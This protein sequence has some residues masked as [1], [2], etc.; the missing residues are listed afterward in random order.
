MK[1]ILRLL[2]DLVQDII[3]DI[4]FIR[5]VKGKKETNILLNTHYVSDMALNALIFYLILSY[6]FSLSNF[7][8]E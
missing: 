2:F 8:L 5:P 3:P 1:Q 7:L 4:L 6:S